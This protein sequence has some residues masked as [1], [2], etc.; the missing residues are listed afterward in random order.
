M[1]VNQRLGG[2]AEREKRRTVAGV[3]LLKARATLGSSTAPACIDTEKQLRVHAE[4]SR[5]EKAVAIGGNLLW[6]LALFTT[7]TD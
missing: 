5:R 6:L 2:G 1:L 3:G 7:E 4:A